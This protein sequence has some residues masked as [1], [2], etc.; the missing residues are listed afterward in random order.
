MKEAPILMI[1]ERALVF[2]KIR[3]RFARNMILYAMPESPDIIEH[4]FKEI[5]QLS[6][7]DMILK[8]RLNQQNKLLSKEAAEATTKE[9]ADKGSK[10]NRVEECKKIIKE[11]KVY[12]TQRSIVGLFS[13]FDSIVLERM[14]GTT[15]YRQLLTHE[16]K[17]SFNFN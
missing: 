13:K 1:T 5:M 4:S 12:N 11:G 9:Q 3:V 2:Q 8:Q 16:T 17:D 10:Q 6:N 14:V 7:W 15:Q